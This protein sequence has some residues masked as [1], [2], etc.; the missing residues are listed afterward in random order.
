MAST[1]TIYLH[2]GLPK[3]GTTYMQSIF[4]KEFP[5]YGIN[6]ETKLI[7]CSDASGNGYILFEALTGALKVEDLGLLLLNYFDKYSSSL[8]S[9]EFLCFL[10]KCEIQRLVEE[11]EKNNIKPVFIVYVRNPVEYTLSSYDQCLKKEFELRSISEWLSGEIVKP[12]NFLILLNEL[13]GLEVRVLNYN[14]NKGRLLE[15]ILEAMDVIDFPSESF[16]FDSNI[17]SNRSLSNIE[18][19]LLRKVN[20]LYSRE[21][22]DEFLNLSLSDHVDR[23]VCF[24]SDANPVPFSE[25]KHHFKNIIASINELY[26]KDCNRINMNYMDPDDVSIEK[27]EAEFTRVANL[28]LN[29][30][31]STTVSINNNLIEMVKARLKSI[32]NEEFDAN[33]AD[34]PVDFDPQTY[35]LLNLDVLISGMDPRLHYSK[36]G[37]CELRGYKI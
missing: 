31:L 34:I 32:S 36:Y 22:L 18:R 15:S 21:F 25:I 28:L 10:N 26:L 13:G 29:T 33:Y 16:S 9:S 3:T 24:F 1:K 7:Q 20:A 2:C 37:R 14:Q 12:Y 5:K 6:Y 8:C 23:S 30:I 35:L 4:K 11:C 17:I 27:L 19:E